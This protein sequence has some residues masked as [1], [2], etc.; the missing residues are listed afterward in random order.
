MS[1]FAETVMDSKQSQD[2][3]PRAVKGAELIVGFKT[4]QSKT[5][6]PL[7]PQVLLDMFFLFSWLQ[8]EI[9]E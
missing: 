3:A 9:E 1:S 2:Y 4:K 6:S 8:Q 7:P 5:N